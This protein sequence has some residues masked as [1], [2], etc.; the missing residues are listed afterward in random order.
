M[1]PGG[2]PDYNTALDVPRDR[3]EFYCAWMHRSLLKCLWRSSKFR[4]VT[5]SSLAF[6]KLEYGFVKRNREVPVSYRSSFC[7][8][9]LFL[10]LILQGMWSVAFVCLSSCACCKGGE[11][12]VQACILC[13]KNWP[14]YRMSPLM[15]S[16]NPKIAPSFN[17]LIQVRTFTWDV[18]KQM[19]YLAKLKLWW[20]SSVF[21]ISTVTL[22]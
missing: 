1:L 8:N 12:S 5:D 16:S 3:Y 14:I 17:F 20:F 21:V 22:Y 10:F 19:S 15:Q 4:T 2:P 11:C 9:N 13:Y 7:S 18:L 6:T